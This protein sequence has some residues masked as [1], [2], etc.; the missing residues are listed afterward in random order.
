[1]YFVCKNEDDFTFLYFIGDTLMFRDFLNVDKSPLVALSKKSSKRAGLLTA[2]AL[3]TVSI[4]TGVFP[5]TVAGVS[6]TQPANAADYVIDQ[7]WNGCGYYKT[8][9]A[10][11]GQYTYLNKCAALQ[12]AD[13]YG[14]AVTL[15][16][17]LVGVVPGWYKAPFAAANMTNNSVRTSLYHCA[18]NNGQAYLRLYKAGGLVQ[19]YVSCN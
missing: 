9:Q 15:T 16:N 4:S 5:L 6:N 2:V 3:A 14:I 19:P 13:R 10:W 8:Q 11:W 17:L 18:A 7:G 12:V 1:L